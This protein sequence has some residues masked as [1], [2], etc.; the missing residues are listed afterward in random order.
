MPKV[1]NER[2]SWE[3]T[4]ICLVP[5]P[6]F[7]HSSILNPAASLGEENHYSSWSKDFIV[8]HPLAELLFDY[9]MCISLVS[10]E[11]N[12]KDKSSGVNLWIHPSFS[13]ILLI[14]P[15]EICFYPSSCRIFYQVKKHCFGYST[16]SPDIIVLVYFV[17]EVLVYYPF[18]STNSNYFLRESEVRE[19]SH[20]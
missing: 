4:S 10:Y 11:A 5:Y 2:E 15:G 8:I 16:P 6:H 13:L 7:C 19:R 1:A 9:G 12:R 3:L 14:S 20:M 17:I 18:S